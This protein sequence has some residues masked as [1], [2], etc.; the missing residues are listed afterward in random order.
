MTPKRDISVART[1]SMAELEALS[2]LREF[3]ELGAFVLIDVDG[4]MYV[5]H[6]APLPEALKSRLRAYCNEV[7]RLLME[8]TQ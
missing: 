6:R 3:R 8:C 1:P 2:V 4:C 7:A 5:Y